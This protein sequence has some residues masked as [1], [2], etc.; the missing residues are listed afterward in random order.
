MPSLA[1]EGN[2]KEDDITITG[3][4]VL[5]TAQLDIDFQFFGVPNVPSDEESSPTIM[6]SSCGLAFRWRGAIDDDSF[7]GRAE[8]REWVYLSDAPC[9]GTNGVRTKLADTQMR[10]RIHSSPA[11][12]GALWQKMDP[13]AYAVESSNWASCSVID[14][15]VGFN[16]IISGTPRCGPCVWVKDSTKAEIA[17]LYAMV[18]DGD[19]GNI[20][21]CSWA[22]TSLGSLDNATIHGT[23]NVAPSIGNIFW[24][25]ISQRPDSPG[26]NYVS[27]DLRT[28]DFGTSLGYAEFL[29]EDSTQQ[30]IF[31]HTNVRHS[32]CG[33]GFVSIGGTTAG[34]AEWV[35]SADMSC[36]NG[37]V[38]FVD[39]DSSGGN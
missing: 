26:S 34:E 27:M 15:Y 33:M 36:W 24:I 17:Y 5:S 12:Y 3:G 10:L 11:C 37:I 22:G 23:I 6:S 19:A 4:S 7:T 29:F 1:H 35:H 2:P 20:K 31:E 9:L 18:F 14:W 38:P 28:A 16:G 39:I 32:K 30:A 25:T 8:G 13:V 21:L